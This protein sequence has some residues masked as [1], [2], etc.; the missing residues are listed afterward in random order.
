[1]T[2][3]SNI[4]VRNIEQAITVTIRKYMEPANVKKREYNLCM[5]K[6]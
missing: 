2:N 6:I 5:F 4:Y 3:Q 1:M